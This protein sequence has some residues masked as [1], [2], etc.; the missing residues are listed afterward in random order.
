MT[1]L[2]PEQVIKNVNIQKSYTAYN[3]M[4]LDV[5]HGNLTQYVVADLKKSLSPQSFIQQ[6]FRLAPINILPKIIDKLTN[7]YQ[8]VVTREV[9]DG[10]VTDAEL[11][12]WYVKATSANDAMNQ[13]NEYYNL[14]KA[15]LIYPYVAKG[16]PALRVIQNDKFAVYS[17][18]TIEPEKPTHVTLFGDKVEGVDIYWTW[19]DQEFMVSDSDGNVRRDLMAA[20]DNQ[21]GV[22]PIGR[23]P[24]V[25]VNESRNRLLPP[26]DTDVMTMVK[27]LPVMLSDLNLASMFQC[28]SIIYGID[29]SDQA[30]TFSPNAF[31]SLKSDATSD[32]KPEIGTIK[33]QVDYDQV[34]NLVQSQLSMWLSS[35]G[36][37]AGSIGSLTTDNVA[38]GISKFIDEMDTFEARQKQVSTFKKA[39][40]ELWDLVLKYMHPYWSETGMI[41]N[42]ARF[43]PSASVAVS[44][45]VQLPQQSRGTA[46]RDLKEEFAAGFISRR[47]ALRKLNPDM[48]DAELNELLAEIDAER[49]VNYAEGNRD[50]VESAEGLDEVPTP[51]DSGL[52]D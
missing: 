48:T 31:W 43:T 10:S 9:V 5:F 20:Y 14:L 38:S 7:I 8:T 24:F 25:Y 27:L 40:E 45:A 49:D 47:R 2:T 41:D 44:F 51:S 30:L 22:N 37:R 39:D 52:S 16:K 34:L 29:V 17:N 42:P 32:K 3:A 23:L 12:S 35:K 18:D 21:L 4:L 19:S 33:P 13:A 46:V 26:Q 1:M 15:S 36:I 50:D 28:F 6:S 11:L